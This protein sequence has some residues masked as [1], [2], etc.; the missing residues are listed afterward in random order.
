MLIGRNLL[1]LPSME[2][3]AAI[4]SEWDMQTNKRG[5]QPATMPLMSLAC[6]AI[7]QV[8]VEPD[9]S[10]NTCMNYLPTDSALFFAPP[11]DRILL[12]KQ[13]EF[14]QPVIRWMKRSFHIEL[15]TT[16]EFTAKLSH[17]PIVVEKIHA[18]VKSLVSSCYHPP[19]VLRKL[20]I[21]C[22]V[23]RRIHSH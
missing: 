18:M 11:E 22:S 6:T 4:A 16:Q 7:D 5:I 2:L 13:K 12:R 9:A 15:S 10:I 1:Y 3:A 14:Y 20:T 19:C 21:I 23:W 17:S 8:S